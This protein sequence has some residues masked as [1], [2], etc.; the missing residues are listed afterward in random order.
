MSVIDNKY[1]GM[2]LDRYLREIYGMKQ[3]LIERALRKKQILIS[4]MKVTSSYRIQL[5]DILEIKFDYNHEV[6]SNIYNKNIS[7]TFRKNIAS[8]EIY[9]DKDFIAF[10]KPSGVSVQSGTKIKESMDDI[11]S[12]FCYGYDESPKIVHRLDKDTSGVIIF[13]R[14]RAVAS[15]ISKIFQNREIIKQ[16]IAVVHGKISEDHG[17]IDKEIG[18]KII[19]GEEMMSCSVDDGMKACTKFS[20]LKRGEKYTTVSVFPLSGRK[21]Q[22]RVHLSAIGH[23]IIGD[24]K[25]GYKYNIKNHVVSRLLLHAMTLEFSWENNAMKLSADLPK[26][27][28]EYI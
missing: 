17:I 8:C 22:I 1:L 24:N 15:C 16:Y 25:Y 26:N 18:R 20:V 4:G 21:H 27:F 13:A 23:P 11:L 28:Q 7:N 2:R 10:N 5:S 14:T 12:E 9:R 19:S 6:Q 3:S